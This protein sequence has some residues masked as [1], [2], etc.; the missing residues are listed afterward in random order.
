MRKL[1]R[2]FFGLAVLMLGFVGFGHAADPDSARNCD[3]ATRTVTL[4]GG[5]LH[6]NRA[7]TGPYILL[8]HGLFAQKEQ[9]NGVR[10]RLSAAGY[11]A[12]APDLPGYGQSIEFP[13]ADYPLDHQVALLRQF[14]DRLGLARFDLAGSSLGGTIAALYVRRHPRQVRT[15][16]F[17]G[18]PL[19][20]IEWSP[21]VKAAMDR[22]I[23]PFIPINMPQFDLEMS[24]LFINPP[25]ISEPVKAAL[26]KDYVERNRHDQQVWNIV[27]LYDT[28]L[29]PPRRSGIPTLILWGKQDPIFAVEG[30]DRLHRR[31]PRGKRVRLSKA[32]YLP[33][34]ETAE[35]TAEVDLDFLR[36]Q[37]APR[38][39][40]R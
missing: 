4:D 24:L 17:I 33:L 29:Y 32:G 22:G 34:L 26:V 5:A 9:W 2:C 6:Y 38:R 31:F 16:A 1:A 20:I 15:L 13:L 21:Q 18:A 10:C 12:I 14:V 30:A 3:I 23:H 8:L 39:W 11:A 37:A 25:S 19:G 35:E 36:T 40:E 7:G 27:N 28:V